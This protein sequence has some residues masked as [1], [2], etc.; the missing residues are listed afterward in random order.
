[1]TSGTKLLK[2]SS[3]EEIR[4]LLEANGYEPEL[5]VDEDGFVSILTI[6]HGIHIFIDFGQCDETCKYCE[7][8]SFRTFFENGR[9]HIRQS[10]LDTWHDQNWVR[11]YFHGTDVILDFC[12]NMKAGLN[13]ENF[14]YTFRWFADEALKFARA[15]NY[16]NTDADE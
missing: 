7:L 10:Q 14:L 13:E 11:T 6:V 8:S 1:M 2:Q 15:F 3:H 4:A 9:I 5:E 16:Y 12:F